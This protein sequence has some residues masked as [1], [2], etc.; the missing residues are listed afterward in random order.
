MFQANDF[1]LPGVFKMKVQ[2]SSKTTFG[3]GGG[4]GGGGGPKIGMPPT[5]DSSTM[6]LSYVFFSGGGGGGEG[7]GGVIRGILFWDRTCLQGI[8]TTRPATDRA[9]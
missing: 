2:I 6:N 8:D 3:G 5:W 7:G 4:G 9:S 1:R